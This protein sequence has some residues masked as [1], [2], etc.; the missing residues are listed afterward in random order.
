MSLGFECRVGMREKV[1]F[2]LSGDFFFVLNF[3][4]V[5][6]LLVIKLLKFEFEVVGLFICCF[7][8]FSVVFRC[9]KVF[10]FYII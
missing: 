2:L 8:R 4:F 10:K 9:L 5:Y 6:L 7:I 3:V 1:V